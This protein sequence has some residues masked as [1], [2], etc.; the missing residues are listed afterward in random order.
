MIFRVH[1]FLKEL[2]KL[3]DEK[4]VALVTGATGFVGKHLVKQLLTDRWEVH[5][6]VRSTSKVAALDHFLCSPICYHRYE[7]EG[8]QVVGIVNRVKP[9]V[10]FHL[11]SLFLTQHEFDD[12]AGLVQSNI[13][14]GAQLLE[15]MVHNKVYNMV[16]AGT[17]W[18]HYN[19]DAYNPVNLYA[20]TKHAFESIQ[21]YYQEARGLKVITLK[22]FDTYGPDDLRPKIFNLLR[23]ASVT[24]EMLAMTPGGQ[25]IDLVYIDDVV[26]AFVLA[27]QYVQEGRNL[28][29]Y[30]VTSGQP[31]RLRELARKYEEITGRVM[32]ITWGGRPYRE[33]E[34]MMPWNR[35]AILPGWQA[36]IRLDQGITLCK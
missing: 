3:N 20:A 28:G 1:L 13:A 32:D 22:L 11:A 26:D 5:V 34:V 19:N 2:A 6:L 35:G 4:K 25:Y 9:N 31:I 18:Q 12:I 16:N 15:A 30:A 14:F 29:D 36:K 8:N 17:S 7:G 33:R 21:R 10:V 24:Q 23:Q 27:A